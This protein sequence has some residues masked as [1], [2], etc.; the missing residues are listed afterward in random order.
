MCC[1]FQRAFLRSPSFFI[2]LPLSFLVISFFIFYFFTFPGRCFGSDRFPIIL[3]IVNRST[4]YLSILAP[5][6]L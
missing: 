2:S 5:E 3:S 1:D 6:A 4:L